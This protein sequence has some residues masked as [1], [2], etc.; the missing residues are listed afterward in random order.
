M[1]NQ[2]RDP[3]EVVLRESAP[4][5][6]V[7]VLT[8]REV[9]LGGLRAMPVRR[10]LPQRQRSL[11]GAWCFVDH[12]GPDRVADTGGMSVAPHPH[13]GLQTVS[14]LFTGEIEH[15]DSAGNH[16]MVR[17]GEVNLMTAG[18]GISH[19]EVSTPDTTTLHGAQ[20]WVALPSAT[21]DA[22][23]G[24]AHHAPTPVTGPGWEARVFLGSLLGDTSPVP[25]HTPLLG[26]ELLLAQGTTLTLDVEA[27][28]EHGV[29]LDSGSLSVAGQDLK[30]AEL[31]YLAP[32]CSS[33]ELTAYDDSRL[34]LLGGE[35]L[36]EA[37][38]MWWNFVGRTH[39]EIVQFREEWQAQITREGAV[40]PDG[41]VV[42]DG[43]FGIVVD[44]HLQ[45]IPAP[46]LPNARLR[47]RH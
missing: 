44:D 23:P 47:E 14:W 39:E 41:Q 3:G 37:I 4:D 1:S 36:G 29:L 9:P 15:R 10:T 45:P 21:R 18:R 38:V 12:Y 19:S 6:P 11:I 28:F 32:G 27:G 43:R 30:P 33:I 22:E 46:T 34:L 8:P 24:F 31:A 35:P 26:A 40:V 7:E 13:T 17:P 2:E 16:A 25:T 5:A 42:A 20:L